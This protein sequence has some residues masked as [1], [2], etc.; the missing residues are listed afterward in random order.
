LRIIEKQ[1]T[2]IYN[3]G[4]ADWMRRSDIALLIAQKVGLQESLKID[5]IENIPEQN[6]KKFGLV[7]LKAE[8]ELMVKPSLLDNSLT[9]MRYQQNIRSK[10]RTIH[11]Y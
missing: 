2:G 5:T 9:T 7:T 8:S 11:F 10:F 4:G 1:R 6:V 3:A